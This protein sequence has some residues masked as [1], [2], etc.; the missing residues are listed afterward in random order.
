MSWC[1][2]TEIISWEK[3][4]L[5]WYVFFRVW[6][7]RMKVNIFQTIQYDILSLFEVISANGE[8][9]EMA[10]KQTSCIKIRSGNWGTIPLESLAFSWSLKRHLTPQACHLNTHHIQ[11]SAVLLPCTSGTVTIPWNINMSSLHILLCKVN[12]HGSY[13]G[14]TLHAALQSHLICMLMNNWYR[15]GCLL[16]SIA[17]IFSVF[18]CFC[19]WIYNYPLMDE[20]DLFQICHFPLDSASHVLDK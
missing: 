16:Q 7:H 10:L 15:A 6:S 8:I 19:V 3:I 20:G 12:T 1:V 9:K 13:T 11:G 2:N 17:D 18:L 4:S 14:M 5:Y